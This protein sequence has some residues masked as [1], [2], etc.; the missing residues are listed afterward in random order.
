MV[1]QYSNL[2][3]KKSN[4]KP[5]KFFIINLI[6]LLWFFSCSLHPPTMTNNGTTSFK[7]KINKILTDSNLNASFGIKI[8]SLKNNKILYE[9]NSNKL[10]IPASNIKLYTSLAA[11]HYLGKKFIFKTSVLQ[12][13]K[14]LFLKGG[15]DPDLTLKQL[16]SL[17]IITAKKIKSVDTL[18]LDDTML[19]SIHYGEGWMW[20]EGSWQYAAQIGALSV[21]NNC[22]DFF[23]SPNQI[24]K[25]AII[26]YNPQTEYISIIN[27]STT[28][29]NSIDINKLT[30]DREWRENKNHFTIAG[31]VYHNNGIDTLQRNI[32]DPTLFTGTLF[33]EFLKNHGIKINYLT[34][35]P[36]LKNLDTL[37]VHPSKPLL[38]STKNLM[39]ESDNLTAELF[40]KT[41]G[42][43]PKKEKNWKTGLDSLKTLLSDSVGID[44]TKLRLADG[45]GLSRYNLTSATQIT[46]LLQWIFNSKYKDDFISTLPGGGWEGGTMEDRFK[47]EEDLI[48]VKTGSLSGVNNLSGYIYSP[49]YGPLAFSILI[50][51]FVGSSK[52]F[53]QLQTKIIQSLIYD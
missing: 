53:Q 16:D 21:N 18:F 3:L 11:L 33:K 26:N 14:N 13:G 52:P 49:K 1:K 19:D 47:D 24:G 9:I 29:K 30:V 23:I 5:M 38:S 35:K 34:K 45:S 43:N 12:N 22:I 42:T 8:I 46:L 6:V 2:F 17:A 36:V 32:H 44:T 31:S 50:N 48:R 51:G 20:D 27:N 28:L 15:G 40:I 10:F 41:I 7:R 25:P 39:N 4:F 37:S